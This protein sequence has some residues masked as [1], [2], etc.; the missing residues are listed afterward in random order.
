MSRSSR[1]FEFSVLT[2]P[3]LHPGRVKKNI[4]GGHLW[5]TAVKIK[6]NTYPGNIACLF[7]DTDRFIGF[8]LISCTS[9]LLVLFL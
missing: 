3:F 8:L 2:I 6:M 7:K 1:R 5:S 4:L 9:F